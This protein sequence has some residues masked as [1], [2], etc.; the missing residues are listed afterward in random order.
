MQ[1]RVSKFSVGFS[2]RANGKF[3]SFG[4]CSG[5]LVRRGIWRAGGGYGGPGVRK[6]DLER[7]VISL[8]DKS[9]SLPKANL[10]CSILGLCCLEETVDLQGLSSPLGSRGHPGLCPSSPRTFENGLFLHLQGC[11]ACEETRRLISV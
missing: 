8:D 5:S 7:K 2:I 4:H 6:M 3:Q 10:D 1:L 11:A 9:T